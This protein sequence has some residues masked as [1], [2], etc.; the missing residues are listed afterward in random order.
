MQ[1]RYARMLCGKGWTPS[2]SLESRKI[3]SASGWQLPGQGNSTLSCTRGNRVLL[4]RPTTP[5]DGGNDTHQTPKRPRTLFH[6]GPNTSISTLTNTTTTTGS[7]QKR[8]PAPTRVILEVAKLQEQMEHYMKCP[9]CHREVSVTF[10]TTCIASG[11]RVECVNKL[12]DFVDV[13]QPAV[14][15]VP[16]PDT[17][18]H[19]S[20]LLHRII[21]WEINVLCMLAFLSVG[22]G[23]TEASRLLG[24][25]G[26]PNATTF[27][28]RSFCIIEEY[29]GPLIQ[30]MANEIV[31]GINLQEEV[32]H[33]F[34]NK[35][36]DNGILLYDLWKEDK[37]P[38]ELVPRLS[39]S[40]DMGWQGRSSGNSYNSLSDD[41]LLVGQHTQKP[42]TWY[43][44]GKACSYCQGWMR[45]VKGKNGEA[46]PQ[47]DCRKNWN[48]SSGAME[49]IVI[50]EMDKLLCRSHCVIVDRIVT[51]DD[52]SIKSC[53]KWNN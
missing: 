50:L 16:M 21:D 7:N 34:G 26:L 51:D 40:G 41:A 12:C 29:L 1:S 47:H 20:A 38:E 11:S 35:T 8:V 17:G 2:G 15:N 49:P 52:S 25:L 4:E 3:K 5:D 14:A 28:P 22:D 27:G 30:A 39:V 46:I 45:G 23:G 9:K 18:N 53:L 19:G 31:C 43:V 48:G 33:E 6:N 36:N 37:L 44:L 13:S 32:K 42:I 24:L 10:P